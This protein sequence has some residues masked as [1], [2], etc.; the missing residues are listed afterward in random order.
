MVLASP[1]GGPVPLDPKS[2]SILAS[3]PTIRKFQKDPEGIS[4]L[5]HSLPLRK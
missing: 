1:Q 2:E 5:E 4:L 3:T